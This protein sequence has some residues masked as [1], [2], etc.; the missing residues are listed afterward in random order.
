MNLSD[1]LREKLPELLSPDPKKPVFGT[2]I[3]EK[4]LK[5][6]GDRYTRGSIRSAITRL[7]QDTTSPIARVDDGYGYYRR[8][9]D[10]TIDDESEDEYAEPNSAKESTDAGGRQYQR[11]EKFRRLYMRFVER[12]RELTMYVDHTKSTRRRPAGINKWKFPDVVHVQWDL[13]GDDEH[14]ERLDGNVLVVKRS[15]GEEPFVITSVELKVEVSAGNVRE[16][17]FQC[18]SNSKWAHNA[19]LAVASTVTDS[20]IANELRRLGKSYGVSV[21]S[22]GLDVD[23]LDEL[24]LADMIANGPD[25]DFDRIIADMNV[26]RIV[27]GSKRASLDWDHIRNMRAL[28]DRFQRLFEWISFC[29]KHNQVHSFN[30]YDNHSRKRADRKPTKSLSKKVRSLS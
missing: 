23:Y 24:P 7:S 30:D 16:A 19:V 4:I 18:V 25:K 5:V 8:L 6:T 29:L 28:N 3:V 26:E 9:I 14:E 11:E 10:S 12:E 2:Y 22:F 1:I 13:D 17:F 27:D 15:L 20:A 21:V